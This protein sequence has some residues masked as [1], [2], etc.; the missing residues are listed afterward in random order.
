ML[1][2][3]SIL[4]GILSFFPW[5]IGLIPFLGWINWLVMVGCVIGIIF[6]A[7]AK[8][9]AGLYINSTLL[10]VAIVRIVMGGGII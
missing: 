1:N 8:N 9:K 10:V 7:M 4:I 2:A 5:L 3:I 6:G